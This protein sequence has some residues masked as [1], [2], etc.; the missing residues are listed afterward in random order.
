[1]VKITDQIE[2]EEEDEDSDDNTTDPNAGDD[3]SHGDAGLYGVGG[4]GAGG[5]GTGGSGAGDWRSTRG[6][7]FTHS[8]QDSYH[9]AP[10]SQR[11][12]ISGRRRSVP[13]PVQDG[14]RSSSSSGSSN[15]PTGQDLVYN[16]YAWQWQPSQRTYGPPLPS[17][18]APPS[19]MY[20][21]GNYGPP[22]PYS[23]LS[24]MYP[25]GPQYGYGQVP[26]AP[27]Y[28]YQYDGLDQYHDPS[29][30]LEYYHYDSS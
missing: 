23:N 13:F 21:Y 22:P 17:G 10:H 19:I 12:T 25:P 20:G 14:I 26:A 7:R 8:T 18:E 11:G 15:Y 30:I 5:S 2:E 3:G 28:H 24:N 16:P 9:D 6:S 4:S 29:N 27:T 1:M